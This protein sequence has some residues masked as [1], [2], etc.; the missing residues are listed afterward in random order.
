MMNTIVGRDSKQTFW[1]PLLDLYGVSDLPVL[2]L[3]SFGDDDD[4]DG[5]GEFSLWGSELFEDFALAASLALPRSFSWVGSGTS[6]LI[7]F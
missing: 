1:S 2:R 7:L 5:G 6:G 3:A 4:D